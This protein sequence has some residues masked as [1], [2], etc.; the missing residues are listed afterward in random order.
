MEEKDTLIWCISLTALPHLSGSNSCRFV[1]RQPRPVSGCRSSRLQRCSL[2]LGHVGLRQDK[3]PFELHNEGLDFWE[4]LRRKPQQEAQFSA[5]M[6][7][8]DAS[9]VGLS[10]VYATTPGIGQG[11]KGHA[12][13]GH[14]LHL[15]PSPS[16]I[17]SLA[18]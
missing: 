16:S 10:A 15:S 8:A 9:G 17:H 1:G 4:Y 12:C 5:A 3:V 13:G 11:R 2:L 14:E 18:P 6:T 7:A